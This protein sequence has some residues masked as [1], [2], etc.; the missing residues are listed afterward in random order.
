M[1]KTKI[2]RDISCVTRRSHGGDKKAWKR[3]VAFVLVFG[4]LWIWLRRSLQ[5]NSAHCFVVAIALRAAKTKKMESEKFREMP[6]RSENLHLNVHFRPLQIAVMQCSIKRYWHNFRAASDELSLE[7]CLPRELANSRLRASCV[8]DA[9][10]AP[11]DRRSSLR[12]CVTRDLDREH[13]FPRHSPSPRPNRPFPKRNFSLSLAT[14]D[15][16]WNASLMIVDD[17]ANDHEA[18][19][20]NQA[21]ERQK[22]RSTSCNLPFDDLLLRADVRDV[23]KSWKI[24]ATREFIKILSSWAPAERDLQLRRLPQKAPHSFERFPCTRRPNLKTTTEKN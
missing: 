20:M 9:T 13:I 23:A 21:E 17:F 16:T 15:G 1:K 19:W 2:K 8:G 10:R 3:F 18:M 6:S 14:F 11:R 7:M 12:S 24:T 5:P 22:E 4:T